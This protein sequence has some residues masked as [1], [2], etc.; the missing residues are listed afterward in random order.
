M[1]SV[2]EG[3]PLYNLRTSFVT[4]NSKFNYKRLKLLSP[5]SF[6]S[7]NEKCAGQQP[8]AGTVTGWCCQ[9][10][11]VFLSQHSSCEALSF[12]FSS[13]LPGRNNV[14]AK[15]FPWRRKGHGS[16][17]S[18]W[19]CLDSNIAIPIWRVTNE[20]KDTSSFSDPVLK[21]KEVAL[22]LDVD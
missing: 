17:G 3:S 5:T 11:C 16:C 19:H 10:L 1:P 2:S 21:V 20:S 18:Y 4:D 6:F 15:A 9:V 14:D 8:G 22:G 13:Q 7:N 12:L